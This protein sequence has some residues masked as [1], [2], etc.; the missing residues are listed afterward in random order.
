M[1][2]CGSLERGLHGFNLRVS[3]PGLHP[4]ALFVLHT[5]ACCCAGGTSVYACGGFKRVVSFPTS[6]HLVAPP[7]IFPVPGIACGLDHIFRSHSPA[8]GPFVD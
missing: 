8:L 3:R 5:D 7:T 6:Q 4:N 2:G 1:G